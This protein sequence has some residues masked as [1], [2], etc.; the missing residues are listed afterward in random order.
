[1]KSDMEY[2]IVYHAGAQSISG[3]V[4]FPTWGSQGWYV[5]PAFGS[6]SMSEF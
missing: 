1:M 2:S 3:L 5:Q 4:A 6:K